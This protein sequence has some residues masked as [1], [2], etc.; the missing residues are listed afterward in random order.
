MLRLI[1]AIV[2]LAEATCGQ[3]CAMLSGQ[4]AARSTDRG[5]GNSTEIV[6]PFRPKVS[7][8]LPYQSFRD[9]GRTI[10]VEDQVY[11]VLAAMGREGGL[12]RGQEAEC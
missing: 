12:A 2:A 3:G 6:T 4:N 9:N 5:K 10:V 11:K 1:R 8:S 7:R